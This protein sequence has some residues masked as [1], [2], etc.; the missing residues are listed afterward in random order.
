M[1]PPTRRSL[2]ATLGLGGA[3]AVAGC[4]ET[5]RNVAPGTPRGTETA[6]SPAD[7]PSS[8]RF[9]TR[10]FVGD[11]TLGVTYA[12]DIELAAGDVTL[13]A[14]GATATWADLRG[15][16]RVER[17]DTVYLGPSPA[18]GRWE[19]PIEAGDTLVVGVEREDRRSTVFEA[20]VTPG[21]A[22]TLDCRQRRYGHDG[23]GHHP[24]A[25]GPTARPDHWWLREFDTPRVGSPLVVDG[26]VVVGTS[27]GLVGL[28]GG[29]LDREWHAF[30][31]RTAVPAATEDTV[32]AAVGT[33]DAGVESLVALDRTDRTERWRADSLGEQWSFEYPIPGLTV[34]GESV[35]VAEP[36]AAHCYDVGSGAHRWSYRTDT[37]RGGG[38]SA[39]GDRV[40]LAAEDNGLHVLDLA[41]GE[42]SPHW[43]ARRPGEGSLTAPAVSDEQVF[44]LDMTEGA[45]HAWAIDA[46]AR[47]W[48]RDLRQGGAGGVALAKD[49]VYCTANERVLALDADSGDQRWRTE[50]GIAKVSEPV[51]ADGHVYVTA[52]PFDAERRARE[53]SRLYVLDAA[54]GA[55]VWEQRLSPLRPGRDPRD[56][57]WRSAPPTVLD[58][59]VIVPDV[60]GAIHRFESA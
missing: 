14:G 42:P 53:G 11:G 39:S 49:S 45:V 15:E 12:D 51:I 38:L 41:T 47:A 28:D 23:T 13:A 40:Y 60:I 19:R 48:K 54:D 1:S 30:P 34:V 52:A 59:V 3:L 29:T 8:V 4:N 26:S 10:R 36:G 7:T 56:K 44:F 16:G 25:T 33:V 5:A 55:V 2:L 18:P 24:D 17:G 43:L 37:P 21:T 58:D 32:L 6:T 20:Q 50:L 35:L 46:M 57:V 9:R 31:G 22:P 27:D